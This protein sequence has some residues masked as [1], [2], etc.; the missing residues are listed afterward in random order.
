M[1]ETALSAS[2]KELQTLLREIVARPEVAGA[3]AEELERVFCVLRDYAYFADYQRR[4]LADLCQ[5]LDQL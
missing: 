1:S 3:L 5:E 2:R 4:E